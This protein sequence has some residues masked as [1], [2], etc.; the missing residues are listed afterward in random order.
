MGVS[1]RVSMTYIGTS[2]ADLCVV[3]LTT[4][5]TLTA[6]THFALISL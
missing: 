5:K 4:F 2:E 3:G 1:K 6:G